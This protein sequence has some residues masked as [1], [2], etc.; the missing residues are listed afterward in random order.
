MV[1]EQGFFF[2]SP[3][4]DIIYS[5]PWKKRFPAFCTWVRFRD[6][7]GGRFYLYNV[8]FDHSS[9]TNRVNSARLVAQRLSMSL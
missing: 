2:F 9:L 1:L 3:T 7:K 4:P 8:H 5:R 6:A